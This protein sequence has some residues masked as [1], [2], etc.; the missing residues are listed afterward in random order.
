MTLSLLQRLG[1]AGFAAA[2][3]LTVAACASPHRTGAALNAPVSDP[4]A[5]TSWQ[6]TQWTLSGGASRLLPHP[7][8]AQ[9]LTL[10]FT[11]EAGTPRASGFAGCNRY[12]ANYVYAQGLLIVKAPLSTRMA[13]ASADHSRLEGDYLVALTR[14]ASSTIDAAQP[15]PRRLT[16]TTTG[17]D[18]LLFERTQ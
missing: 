1:R 13:C 18:T 12:A 5:Q 9:P 14:I 17:G 8:K 2:V 10:A 7:P 3:V 4:F 16:L 6:L 15:T 11:H